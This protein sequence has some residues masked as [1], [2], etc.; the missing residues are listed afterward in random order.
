[1]KLNNTLTG[2]VLSTAIALNVPALAGDKLFMPLVIRRR[3]G[4]RESLGD[5]YPSEYSHSGIRPA[6][7]GCIQRRFGKMPVFR[8]DAWSLGRP[9]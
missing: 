8:G 7:P 6:T 5:T 9:V 2:L 4:A 1:M 3:Y